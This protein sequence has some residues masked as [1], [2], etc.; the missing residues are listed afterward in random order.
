MIAICRFYQNNSSCANRLSQILFDA[1]I[2]LL[3]V[4]WLS[5]L[6]RS[7]MMKNKYE[8]IPVKQVLQKIGKQCWWGCWSSC[9][10]CSSWPWGT[11]F[12]QIGSWFGQSLHVIA[13]FERVWGKLY[14]SFHDL[15]WTV[16][17]QVGS[18]FSGT[19][20]SGAEHNDEFYVDNN[21][22]IR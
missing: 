16:L 21:G 8:A 12:W 10:K 14:N 17:L 18:G 6:M 3:R 15:A 2:V 13:G 22:R 5:G 19:M 7:G 20:L 1:L 11:G 4:W 9:K